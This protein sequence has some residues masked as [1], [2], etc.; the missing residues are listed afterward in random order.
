M[1]SAWAGT[2]NMQRSEATETAT[3]K[4]SIRA[5]HHREKIMHRRIRRSFAPR[6]KSICDF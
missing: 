6:N 2:A 1:S 5:S 3:I 4:R